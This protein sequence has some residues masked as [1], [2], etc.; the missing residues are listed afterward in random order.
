MT[1][2]GTTYRVQVIC[3]NC[4]IVRGDSIAIPKGKHWHIYLEE[5]QVE[6]ENCGVW[7][8]YCRTT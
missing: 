8:C 2:K 3:T 5:N 4:G 6:C 7:D 1:E